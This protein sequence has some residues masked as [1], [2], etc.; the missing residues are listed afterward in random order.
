MGRSIRISGHEYPVLLPNP[1]DARLHVA[2]VIVSIHV[3]GQ[4]AFD[5]QVSVPQILAAILSCAAF[6]VVMQF[7]TR[8]AIAWPASAMLTGSGVALILRDAGFE[9]GQH[10]SFHHWWWFAMVATGSLSTK[11][12]I[13]WRGSNVLNPS[14]FGLVVA[15]L[16]LGSDRIEPLDF[17]WAPLRAPMIGAYLL[18]IVGGVLITRRAGLLEMAAA[19]WATLGACLG[20]LALAGHCIV[21]TWSLQPVCDARFWRTVMASPETMIFLFFMITDP[22]TVPAGRRE[23]VVIGI[24]VGVV[25]AL[26]VAPWQTEF[27]AKVGLLGGLV[28]VC[29]ARPAVVWLSERTVQRRNGLHLPGWIRVPSIAT[30]AAAVLVVVALAGAPARAAT[31]PQ[32][33]GPDPRD[34]VPV[35]DTAALPRVTAEDRVIDL[36]GGDVEPVTVAAELVRLLDVESIAVAARDHE[37]LTVVDHGVRL[38]GAQ[39]ADRRRRPGRVRSRRSPTILPLCISTWSEARARAASASA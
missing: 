35:V 20:A 17:W 1:R 7:A 22:R 8:R 4:V 34:I 14:N 16:V 31:S 19:F 3:L 2:A 24:C 21:T 32:P 39:P 28:A 11:Y 23:R 27:G 5:F 25:S 29:A 18:I 9:A 36:L 30:G 38:D 33:F 6:E 12:L 15:F 26:F 10:W 13:R 37:M